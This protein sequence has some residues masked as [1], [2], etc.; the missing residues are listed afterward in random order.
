MVKRLA[1]KRADRLAVA[2]TAGEHQRGARGCVRA[3]HRKHRAL[4][5]HAQ[6][7]EAVPREHSVEAAAEVERAHVRHGPALLR[8]T[9]HAQVDHRGRG[10]DAGQPVS[11]FDEVTRDRLAAA[12]SDVEDRSA[13]RH[14]R[15]KPVEPRALE[16][17]APSL[18]VE[19]M[20]VPLIEPD[21]AFR[22]VGHR[23]VDGRDKLAGAR[24][25]SRRAPLAYQPACKPGSVTR[26]CRRVT[27]IPL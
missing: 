8:K 27:A 9:R 11:G 12:A 15:G 25:S 17:V 6:V 26:R 5:L 19:R 10:V 7:E 1:V 23:K 2:R 4:I 16:Q 20:S 14:Q 13:V 21:D 22:V 24:R 18:F 3:E